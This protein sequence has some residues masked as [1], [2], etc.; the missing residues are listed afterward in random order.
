MGCYSFAKQSLNGRLL[1]ALY[2]IQNVCY[3]ILYIVYID[4][5]LHLCTYRSPSWEASVLCVKLLPPPLQFLWSNGLV[6]RTGT[7]LHATLCDACPGLE[8]GQPGPWA[9]VLP[10]ESAVAFAGWIGMETTESDR[11]LCH[12]KMYKSFALMNSQAIPRIQ[13]DHRLI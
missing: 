4:Y 10:F 7:R 12:I 2:K 8:L 1:V 6:L 5:C 3:T 13:I 9:Q 11:N